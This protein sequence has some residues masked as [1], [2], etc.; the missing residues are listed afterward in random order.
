MYDYY[1]CMIIQETWPL[2]LVSGRMFLQ[3]SWRWSSWRWFHRFCITFSYYPLKNSEVPGIILVFYTYLFSC[4]VWYGMVWCVPVDSSV[5]TY[6]M[7][8]C[9]RCFVTVLYLASFF[10]TCFVLFALWSTGWQL[11]Y[12][13]ILSM[14]RW[15]WLGGKY[16]PDGSDSVVSTD[17][18]AVIFGGNGEYQRRNGS[19]RTGLPISA[20]GWRYRPDDTD[21]V[22]VSMRWQRLGGGTDQMTAIGW[23][24]RSDDSDWV[25]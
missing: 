24:Y 20:I 22:G 2:L 4:M 17:V 23:G 15:Q 11:R 6:L 12:V 9:M 7:H 19:D 1:C 13:H 16:Q 3:P 25:V 14:S 5:V 21:W 10:I 8:E 18:T